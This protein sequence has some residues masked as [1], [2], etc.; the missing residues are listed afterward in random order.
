MTII[1]PHK[2]T[3]FLSFLIILGIVLGGGGLFYVFEY[4]SVVEARSVKKAL[5][6]ETVTL[7][8]KNADLKNSLYSMTDAASL[9]RLA[10]DLGLIMEKRPEYL[11][12]RQWLSVSSH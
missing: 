5:R 1:K 7:Q 10:K 3:S 6:A 11:N 9:E 4:A 8:V 2:N 12:E